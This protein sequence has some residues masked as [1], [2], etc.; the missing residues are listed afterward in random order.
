LPKKAA[1]QTDGSNSS[2]AFLSEA[3]H[4]GE[5]LDPNVANLRLIGARKVCEFYKQKLE[6]LGFLDTGFRKQ[7]QDENWRLY[8][9]APARGLIKFAPEVKEPR[10]PQKTREQIQKDNAELEAAIAKTITDERE[11]DALGAVKLRNE[12]G[13]LIQALS[14]THQLR[15][16]WTR[17]DADLAAYRQEL[18]KVEGYE[19][20][21]VEVK[22]KK[23][24]CPECG[25]PL[26]ID[27]LEFAYS[28]YFASA[29]WKHFRIDVS[30]QD[31]ECG[32]SST[33]F[34]DKP[35]ESDS[36]E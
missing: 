24:V 28:G 26:N 2:P 17:Y 35:E 21:C 16:Q 7:D 4:T 20:I 11:A 8:M 32:W 29:D 13:L 25:G 15:D 31:A 5:A 18:H 22:Q 6:R 23:R 19:E 36:D 1:V 9:S 12:R 14:I 34:P 27:P 30:C 3:N 33:I 10:K